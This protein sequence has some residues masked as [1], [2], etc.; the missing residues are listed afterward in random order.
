MRISAHD[1]VRSI[2]DG[3]GGDDGAV[4]GGDGAVV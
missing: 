2:D 3:D 4:G 1:S